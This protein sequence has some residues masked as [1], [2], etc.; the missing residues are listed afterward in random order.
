[1]LSCAV[2][3][4]DYL[5]L[6]GIHATLMPVFVTYCYDKILNINNFKE[7]KCLF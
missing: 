1:M 7:M 2:Q 4:I 6:M 5:Y 3:C